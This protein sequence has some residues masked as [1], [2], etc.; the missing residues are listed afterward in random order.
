MANENDWPTIY[1]RDGTARWSDSSD[2]SSLPGRVAGE[3]YENCV[4]FRLTGSERKQDAA[5]VEAWLKE[6]QI[7]SLR[8]LEQEAAEASKKNV[9]W[10]LQERLFGTTKESQAGSNYRVAEADAVLEE[11][12]DLVQSLGEGAELLHGSGSAP[13]HTVVEATNHGALFYRKCFQLE[14]YL[15]MRTAVDCLP[16]AAVLVINKKPMRCS[17]E[18]LQ[19]INKFPVLKDLPFSI[20]YF[21]HSLNITQ[22]QQRIAEKDETI[23]EKDETIAEKDETIAEKDETIAEKDK[24]IAFLVFCIVL[25]VAY[26]LRIQLIPHASATRGEL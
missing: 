5:R 22:H 26:L 13:A 25:L 15:T 21:P 18:W 3:D 23:A 4:R 6:D 12:K 16:P 2:S 14:K 8:E 11:E 9:G 7:M 24:R 17:E 10:K 1:P 19:A 20:L